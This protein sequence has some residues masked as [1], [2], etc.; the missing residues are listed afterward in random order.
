MEKANRIFFKG[1]PYPA[2]HGIKKFVWSGRLD[3]KEQLWFDLHLETDDYNAEEEE[4]DY[5]DDYEDEDE[6]SD[7]EAKIVWENF[8]S[9]TISS[10]KWQSKGIKINTSQGKFDFNDLLQ[11]PLEVDTLPLEDDLDLEDLS[12]HIYLLGHDSCANHKIKFSRN[13]NNKFDIE[14]TGKIALTYSGEEEFDH[15][16]T[17]YI[18]DVTFD[19]FYLPKDLGLEKAQ[20]VFSKKIRDIENFEFVDLNPKSN[21]REYKLRPKNLQ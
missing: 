20:E 18:Q 8:G 4:D 1:N 2:G 12:F 10:T 14:W 19:G 5:D 15:D 3:E 11:K 13:S 7:W 21:K 17:A 9:C 6:G 16:F